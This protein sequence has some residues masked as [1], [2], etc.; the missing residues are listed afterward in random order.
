MAFFVIVNTF[1]PPS[2]MEYPK[3]SEDHQK[4]IVD[5]DNEIR[6]I[7]NRLEIS[8][9]I[10]SKH[11]DAYE[12]CQQDMTLP[13]VRNDGHDR[14][15]GK[16]KSRLDKKQALID[17]LK[18]VLKEKEE[19]LE[20]LRGQLNE[21]FSF[22]PVGEQYRSSESEFS[23]ATDLDWRIP[24]SRFKTF[25]D[26]FAAPGYRLVPKE[27]GIY[28]GEDY[29]RIPLDVCVADPN[30]ISKNLM[31]E[32]GL[33]TM[34]KGMTQ[35][36]RMKVKAGAIPKVKDLFEHTKPLSPFSPD[37]K[38]DSY[39]L[40]VVEK[41]SP[42]HDGKI[43]CPRSQGRQSPIKDRKIAQ[44][45][46]SAYMAYRKSAHPE[47]G[48][49]HEKA[50]LFA[51]KL[52]VEG[53]RN[54]L[55]GMKKDNPKLAEI[56]SGI[57]AE[58]EDF[59]H[60][61]NHFKREAGDILKEVQP[62]RDL[63]GRHNPGRACARLVKAIGDLDA[64]LPEIMEISKAMHEDKGILS[65]RIMQDEAVMDK[66]FDDF[67]GICGL[68]K[69]YEPRAENGPLFD[70]VGVFKDEMEL[71]LKGMADLET[72]KVRPFNL[73]ASNLKIRKQA[74]EEAL[75]SGD[76]CAVKK[77]AVKAFIVAK[78]FRIQK[79]T[80]EILKDVSLMP[81]DTSVSVLL[82]IAEELNGVA[83]ERQVFPLVET[84]YEAVYKTLKENIRKLVAG[85]RTYDSVGLDDEQKLKM[86]GRLKKYLE[87][88]DFPAILSQ[89]N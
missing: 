61:T 8:L 34:T 57:T 72:L 50:K 38:G 18:T 59:E 44:V 22:D 64:R 67:K 7:E 69:Q 26:I 31:D 65:M 43:I 27:T 42:E 63:L 6:S 83:V 85:L 10:L 82:G 20:R 17:K 48:Y 13:G 5:L 62:I 68:V 70:R 39:R 21:V 30:R 24:N 28:S 37:S 73:Y 66:S 88:I 55:I 12:K 54:Q 46:D 4:R 11:K 45:F 78:I 16:I 25:Q 79:K 33:G 35:F 36:E 32:F 84:E 23:K 14:R 56:Q 77:D 40:L 15:L 51:I 89:L 29:D 3:I 81:S 2:F 19:L 86:Y 9:C 87:D 76:V 47:T 53:Y 52:R 49:E 75:E 58:V 60:V 71:M 74:I 41:Y 80:E 1:N